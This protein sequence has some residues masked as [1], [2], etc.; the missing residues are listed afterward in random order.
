[1][2]LPY[3]EQTVYFDSILHTPPCYLCA[4]RCRREATGSLSHKLFC[5]LAPGRRRRSTG[6]SDSFILKAASLLSSSQARS[7]YSQRTEKAATS[8]FIRTEKCINSQ[9]RIF[10]KKKALLSNIC[11]KPQFPGCCRKLISLFSRL[12]FIATKTN[13]LK[14]TGRTQ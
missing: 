12:V 5:L 8:H 4:Q 7:L 13:P 14:F 9:L 3:R 11:S 10:P 2:L 6:L 1:M